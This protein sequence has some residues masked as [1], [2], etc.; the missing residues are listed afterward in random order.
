MAIARLAFAPATRRLP[1]AKP[2]WGTKRICQSCGARFYDFGRSPIVCPA[3][4][5]VF[6]LEVLNRAR[7]ARPGMRAAV[8]ESVSGG[9]APEE[10]EIEAES[11]VEEVDEEVAVEEDDTAIETEDGEED[12]SLI[13]DASELGDDEDMSDVIE[14]GMDEET[15]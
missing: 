14:G 1:L 3:C 15:R 5:A 12:D 4:S 2:E 8:T 6:D 13:E 11:E 9:S 10:A 7:R